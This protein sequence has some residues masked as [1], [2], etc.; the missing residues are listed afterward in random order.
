MRSKLYKDYTFEEKEKI[1]ADLLNPELTFEE[2][3]KKH[4]AGYRICR[5]I[6]EE[7]N[8][9]RKIAKRKKEFSFDEEFFE[10]ID[11]EEK[12]YW[13]GFLYADGCL[14]KKGEHYCVKLQLA[15][16]DRD[17][18]VKF[19]NSV[20]SNASVNDYIDKQNCESS[21][22][23][24]NS[25]KAFFD[26]IEKGCGMRKTH[27]LVFPNI[28]QVDE[29]YLRHFMRGYFDGDGTINIM[30]D[31][32]QIRFQVLGTSAFLQAYI[33]KLPLPTEQINALKLQKTRGIYTLQ[34]AGNIKA[35]KIFDYM[36][37]DA[38]IF[39]ERKHEIYLNH[40]YR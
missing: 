35:R 6:K 15:K 5:K 24:L 19:R 30:K 37:N 22:L 32:N 9:S 28:N 38:S 20:K 33:E 3:Y 31:C 12:A 7:F 27:E 2:V 26:L 16:K 13:L 4:N 29:R 23:M 1:V 36:Y 18:I 10:K 39:L 8:V 21:R 14:I 11:S 25:K 40:F 17:H 34:I